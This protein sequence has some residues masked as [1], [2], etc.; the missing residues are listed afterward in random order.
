LLIDAPSLC[1]LIFL[2]GVILPGHIAGMPFSDYHLVSVCIWRDVIDHASGRVNNIASNETIVAF[3]KADSRTITRM[4]KKGS[5][6][7]SWLPRFAALRLERLWSLALEQLQSDWIGENIVI[8]YN[9]QSLKLFSSTKTTKW[10]YIFENHRMNK[11]S[12]AS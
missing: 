10:L 7:L 12:S 4:S 3:N 5:L 11:G 2:V 1:S 8:I 6:S 9:I